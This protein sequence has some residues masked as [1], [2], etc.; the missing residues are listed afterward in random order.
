MAY[1]DMEEYEQESREHPWASPKTIAQIVED[2][3]RS[4]KEKMSDNFK[5]RKE[6]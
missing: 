3:K 2:H 6:R 4:L 1:K 5:W